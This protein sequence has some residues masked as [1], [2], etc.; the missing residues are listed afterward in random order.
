MLVVFK[1]VGE[2]VSKCVYCL[3]NKFIKECVSEL[4]CVGAEA[5]Q[6]HYNTVENLKDWFIFLVSWLH[7]PEAFSI[8][9]SNIDRESM[10]TL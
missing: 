10:F 6:T 7:H 4:H 5:P 1:I 9:N 8:K 2:C 3:L